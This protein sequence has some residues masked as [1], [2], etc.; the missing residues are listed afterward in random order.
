[1]EQKGWRICPL[2][3][4]MK[5]QA[6]SLAKMALL[7]SIA[8]G[9][10][11]GGDF[12][13]ELVKIKVSGVQVSGSPHQALETDWGYRAAQSLFS[14]KNII[15]CNDFHLM[16]WDSL[17]AAMAT[18]P[19][20]YRLWLSKHVLDF[21]S[22]NVQLYYCSKGTPSPKCEFCLEY[23]EFTMH[24]AQCWDPGCNSMFSIS[25]QEIEEWIL[26]LLVIPKLLQQ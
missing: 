22:T 6:D 14:D 9:S 13:F 26:K 23:N 2:P 10:I 11:L 16:W 18:Y 12:P 4:C 5:G 24:I 20:I 7:H 25:V 3:E 15:H 8:R 17:G 21:C 19:K 1:M